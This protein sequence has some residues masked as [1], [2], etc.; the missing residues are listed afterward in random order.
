MICRAG[1][2][3]IM[4]LVAL[5]KSALLIPTPGQTEQEYLANYH[6]NQGN[7]HSQKQ[8]NFDL[9]KGLVELRKMETLV[10]IQSNLTSNL[11]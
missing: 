10:E 6:L 7:F 4:D 5:R 1:Y 9:E 3:S 8:A 11:I 2:S